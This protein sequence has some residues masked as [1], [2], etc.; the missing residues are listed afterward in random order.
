MNDG[1]HKTPGGRYLF[2]I[3]LA[4]RIGTE[5]RDS[6]NKFASLSP[7]P[8]MYNVDKAYEIYVGKRSPKLT[9]AQRYKFNG[10]AT[11]KTPG[12]G[13]YNNLLSFFNGEKGITISQ[14]LKAG[15]I[16]NTEE[17]A[18]FPGPGS[19]QVEEVAL[20][21]GSSNKA[22]APKFSFTRGQRN[23][24]AHKSGNFPD[25]ASYTPKLQS[26]GPAITYC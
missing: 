11:E 16:L 6:F 23:A 18:K 19:Y 20:N 21:S 12:P 3:D 9:I 26:K 8:S 17:Q 1:L 2:Y 14:K 5:T 24:G 13:A 7:G 25:P 22:I 4:F 15:N 10:S